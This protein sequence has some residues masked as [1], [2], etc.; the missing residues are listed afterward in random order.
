MSSNPT[1]LYRDV[2][3]LPIEV[4]QELMETNPNGLLDVCTMRS[5]RFNRD[6]TVRERIN[7]PLGPSITHT[8]TG[9]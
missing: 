7:Q 6:G 5:E 3:D 8:W 9:N 2:L 1:T 4:L